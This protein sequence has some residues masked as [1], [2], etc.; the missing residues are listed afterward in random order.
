MKKRNKNFHDYK[1]FALREMDNGIDGFKPAFSWYLDLL[2]ITN[3]S[4][5]I[6]QLNPDKTLSQWW[7]TN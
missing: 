7:N 4:S 5:W 3:N 6:S 2:K 1:V